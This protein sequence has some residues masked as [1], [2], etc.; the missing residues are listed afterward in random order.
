MKKNGTIDYYKRLYV[1]MNFER[2]GLFE[3]IKKEYGCITALYPGCSVHITPSLYFQHVVYVDISEDAKKFF[4]DLQ[5]ILAYIN[6]NKEYK[7]PAHVQFI[8]EDYTKPLPLRE[9]NYDLL[10][11]LYAGRIIKFCRRYVR[12]GGI[13][14][15]NSQHEIAEELKDPSIKLDSVIYS[16]GK[17]YVIEKDIN[18]DFKLFLKR[19]GNDKKNMKKTVKGLEY[20]DNQCYFVLKKWAKKGVS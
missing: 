18:E 12:Y 13:I 9:K 15:T 6:G 1:N 5:S 17:D 14:V 8:Q 3:A 4:N 2:A 19:H 20:V 7:Q 16:K 10:I 11:A